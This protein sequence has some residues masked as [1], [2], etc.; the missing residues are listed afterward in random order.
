MRWLDGISLS[1]LRETVRD[2]EA[3]HAAVHGVT[4]L[5]MTQQLSNNNNNRAGNNTDAPPLVSGLSVCPHRGIL[6]SIKRTEILVCAVIWMNLK[7]MPEEARK[8]KII[9]Y[10]IPFI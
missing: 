8:E 4:E 9:F 10:T 7:N 1:K 6:V 3:W 5:D 2:R